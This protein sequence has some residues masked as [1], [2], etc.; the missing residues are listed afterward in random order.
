MTDYFNIDELN[1]PKGTVFTVC[2][3]NEGNNKE[4]CQTV[5]RGH[6][7]YNINIR[8]IALC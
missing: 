8:M 7:D 4:D 2:V 3:T 5:N 1:V 6:G